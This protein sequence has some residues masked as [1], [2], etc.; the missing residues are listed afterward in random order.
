MLLNYRPCQ[1]RKK[2]YDIRQEVQR[3]VGIGM[4]QDICSSEVKAVWRVRV[5]YEN[6]QKSK[7]ICVGLKYICDQKEEECKQM[8]V[9][10]YINQKMF[11]DE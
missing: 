5:D 2:T 10:F 7:V 11:S 4:C 9:C 3:E 6:V 8:V 1:C